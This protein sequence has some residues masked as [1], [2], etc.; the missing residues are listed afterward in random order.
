M[1]KNFLG[2]QSEPLTVT[3]IH[4]ALSLRMNLDI[5]RKT[6]ERELIEML[7]NQFVLAFLGVPS[8]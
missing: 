7:D 2:M 4:E 6:I 5:S 8:E 1:I 3:A